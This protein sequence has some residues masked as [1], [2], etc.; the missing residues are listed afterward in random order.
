MTSII[1]IETIR[2]SLV[3][4]IR[5]SGLS[6]LP[7]ID[8]PA[9]W[10][11]AWAK[12]AVQSTNAATAM[13]DYQHA[14][15]SGH[16]TSLIDISLVLLN[17]GKP[18]AIWPLTLTLGIK[19]QLSS[20][21]AAIQAP[22]FVAGLSPRTIK[23]ITAAALRF[24]QVFQ[25]DNVQQQILSEEYKT[26]DIADTGLTEWHQQWM[27]SGATVSVRHD[28]YIDLSLTLEQIRASFRKSYRP[29]I[30][31]GLK[32]WSV[33]SIT[34][35]NI[36]ESVWA[37]FKSLHRQVSGRVTRDDQTWALQY[38]MILR[39]EAMLIVLRDATN[40][41][42]MVGAGFFQMTRDEGVYAVAAYDRELFDMP[43]GHV[44]QMSAI[45]IMKQR[46]LRWYRIG[47]RFFP[48][49]TPQPNEKE[50]AISLFKQGFATHLLPRFILNLPL[51]TS[52]LSG[53]AVY[54]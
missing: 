46:G 43:V 32:L 29:L 4:W 8:A 9:A 39:G 21:G 16:G 7:R 13:I 6:A 49:D 26:P 10:Q 20:M 5:E 41:H 22:H 47:E 52:V 25:T 30:S 3:G 11:D 14:Y 12:C 15:L 27:T 38:Q 33:E 36:N 35:E 51:Q 53:S 17:D 1:P 37:E 40:S 28:L 24:V 19:Q 31:S 18:A 44:V 50:L 54:K 45:E 34:Q 23:K 2:T 42:R 48:S